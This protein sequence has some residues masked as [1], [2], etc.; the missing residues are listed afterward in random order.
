M[1]SVH[2]QE[3]ADLCMCLCACMCMHTC[4]YTC[5][6]QKRTLHLPLPWFTLLLWVLVSYWTRDRPFW[7]GCSA[8]PY[9]CWDYRHAQPHPV[10]TWVL[11][12]KVRHRKHYSSLSHLHN[13]LSR[14]LTSVLTAFH[15][16]NFYT[17]SGLHAYD[18]EVQHEQSL[19]INHKDI[20]VKIVWGHAHNFNHL[21]KTRVA[22]QAAM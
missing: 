18:T 8:C 22:L 19:V 14:I 13:P 17:A 11:G 9:Q 7:L 3:C 6:G 4:T 21:L 15:L 10:L 20:N 16:R 5:R 12:F 2:S 1:C